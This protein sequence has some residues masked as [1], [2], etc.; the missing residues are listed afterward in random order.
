MCVSGNV[1]VYTCVFVG[2]SGW[3]SEQDL[4][5]LVKIFRIANNLEGISVF[6]KCEIESI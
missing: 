4:N 2:V 1:G 6:V 5:Y 3:V